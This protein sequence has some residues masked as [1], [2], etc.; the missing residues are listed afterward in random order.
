MIYVRKS[1]RVEASKSLMTDAGFTTTMHAVRIL[2][3][4]GNTPKVKHPTTGQMVEV[5]EVTPQKTDTGVVFDVA[6]SA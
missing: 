2:L 1:F 4:Q 5:E 6:F 3:A